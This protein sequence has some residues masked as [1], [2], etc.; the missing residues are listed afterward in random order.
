[1]MKTALRIALAPVMLAIRLMLG[2]VAFITSITSSVLGLSVSL[3]GLLS[4]IEF[5]IGYWQNG[6]AFMVLAFL[7]SPYWIA[8]NR[9]PSAEPSG[10]SHWFLRGPG[11]LKITCLRRFVC[12]TDRRFFI[13]G[14]MYGNNPD[15]LDAHQ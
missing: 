10:S 14:G 11:L 2:L 6:I 3:F 1:M 7:V 8:C 13:Y 15:H 9:H 5:F 12:I 4:V